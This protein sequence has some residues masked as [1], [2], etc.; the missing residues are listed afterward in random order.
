EAAVVYRLETQALDQTSAERIIGDRHIDEAVLDEEPA[1]SRG[2]IAHV[3]L[4]GQ[5][6]VRTVCRLGRAHAARQAR[7]EVRA[8]GCPQGRAKRCR[9][10]GEFYNRRHFRTRLPY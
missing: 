7:G 6:P 10:V 3:S 8:P 5:K 2:L 9:E 4:P 1:Q